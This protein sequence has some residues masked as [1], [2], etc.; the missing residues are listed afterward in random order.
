MAGFQRKISNT[1]GKVGSW[2]L[3]R[4]ALSKF[5]HSLDTLV[6]SFLILSREELKKYLLDIHVNAVLK[7]MHQ[8]KGC[9]SINTMEAATKINPVP[10]ILQ[11]VK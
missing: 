9:A 3:T 7:R 8:V 11:M 4:N 5:G 10:G 2:E 1:V 6:N